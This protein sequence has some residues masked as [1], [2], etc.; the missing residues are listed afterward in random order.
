MQIIVF[1]FFHFFAKY[2]KQNFFIKLLIISNKMS[3]IWIMLNSSNFSSFL[4]LIFPQARLKNG[5]FN[6]SAKE[7]IRTIVVMNLVAVI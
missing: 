5:N 6:I 3:I 1:H 4:L 7:F 2:A